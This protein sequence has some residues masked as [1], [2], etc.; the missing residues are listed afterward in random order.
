[1]GDPVNISETKRVTI[2]SGLKEVSS[3]RHL[4]SKIMFN[5]IIT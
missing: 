4:I 5:S 2:E 1:M 3:K